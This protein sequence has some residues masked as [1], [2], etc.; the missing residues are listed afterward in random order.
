MDYTLSLMSG[1]DIPIP[2]CN[3]ILHQPTIKEIAYLG[4]TFFFTGAQC[5][6]INKSMYQGLIEGDVNNFDL[7]MLLLQDKNTV[8]K[9][10]AVQQVLQLLFPD[11]KIFITPRSIAFNRANET[12]TIDEGNFESLQNI[13]KNVFCLGS[14]GQES[15]NPSG[16]KAREI[17]D[18][19]MR[20]RQKV[21]QQK[22]SSNSSVLAQYVSVLTVGLS[23]MSLQNLLNLTMYQLYDL[24][25]RYTL[26]TNWDLDIKSKLAGGKSET[27]VENWMKALH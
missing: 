13:L 26:Y 27:K 17:A 2:E 1:I 6:C 8:D 14:A 25:E 5:L 7:L 12:F 19:L 11:Y 21:A 9:K 4:E 23:S 15:Y 24:I 20:A 3:L 22:G 16:K 10:N 18:K